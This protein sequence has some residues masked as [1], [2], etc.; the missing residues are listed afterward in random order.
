M[1]LNLYLLKYFFM[2][3]LLVLLSLI[4]VVWL[5]HALRMLEFIVSKDSSFSD[6][7]L[8]SFFPIPLW[9]VIAMPM[10][11][12]IGVIWGISRFLSDRE[13]IVMQAVGFTPLQFGRVPIFFGLLLM[14]CLYVNS[15]YILPASFS[16]FKEVQAEVR[17]SIPKLLIQDNIFIDI[18]DDLTLFVG[19]RTSQNEV[20]RVFIQDSRN[21]DVTI[22]FTSERGRFSSIN[23]QPMFLLLNGQRT[24]L[25][26]DGQSSAQLTF[27]S[28]SLDISQPSASPSQ[29][30]VLDMNED[31]IRNLLDP[32]TAATPHYARERMA[33]GHYRL[34]SP[35]M[36]LAMVIIAAAIMLQGHLSR[37]KIGQRVL[38]SALAGILI[39]T[40]AIL[41]RGLTVS[42]PAAWPLMYLAILVPI[43]LGIFM[44][45]R[46]FWLTELRYTM[47]STAQNRQK[48]E[49]SG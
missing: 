49:R 21:P 38:F 6:F 20:G 24:E 12:F 1:N 3:S 5:N 27:E 11:A 8:L 30:L 26:K 25:T 37:E 39:Q 2:S 34:T 46:P 13:L 16:K 44:L 7:L 36:T 45:W 19:E 41:T 10:S 43:G 33:M 9:L 15:L 18:A 47:T 17:G 14:T 29:R 48:P 42:S 28:H 32:S 23:G 35:F 22:T 4:G 31:S 40:L